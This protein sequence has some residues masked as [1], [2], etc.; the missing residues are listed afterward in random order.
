MD[1]LETV[2][3]VGGAFAGRISFVGFRIVSF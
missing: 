3:A 2:I 1:A